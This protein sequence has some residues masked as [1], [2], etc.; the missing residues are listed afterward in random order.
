MRVISEPEKMRQN[1]CN[2][3]KKYL[4]S[5]KNSKNLEVGIYNYTIKDA[6]TK[7]VVKKWTNVFF[8]E[9]YINRVRSVLQNLKRDSINGNYLLNL[10]NEKKIK[11]HEI[12]FMT[13]FEMAPEQWRRSF[14][15]SKRETKA[16]MMSVLKSIVNSSVAGVRAI[17]AI[18]TN[19]RREVLMNR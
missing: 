13:H 19:Y 6:T 5:T 10:I 16:N 4:K 12:A 15:K 9:I 2:Q 17:I 18:T 3:I 7:K 8:T 1:I 14:K 11:P